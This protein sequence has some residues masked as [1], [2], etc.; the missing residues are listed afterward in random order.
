MPRFAILTH[1]HPAPHWDLFLE[2]GPVLRSWRLLAP[3]SSAIAVPAEPAADHRLFYLDYEGPV[4]GNRGSVHRMDAGQFTAE[5]EERDR[6][7]LRMDGTRFIGRLILDRA[8]GTWTC[9][10]E[11]A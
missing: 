4:S 5:V 2:A 10:F 1:D 8:G 6:I 11:P 9:T 7:V 3:L